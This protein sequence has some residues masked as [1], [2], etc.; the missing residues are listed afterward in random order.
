MPFRWP[1]FSAPPLI[2]VVIPTF[3]RTAELRLC[4]EG[5]SQQ[6]AP[7][8]QFELVIIDDGSTED[9]ASVAAAFEH[10]LKLEFVPSAHAGPGAA[11]NIGLKRARA[12][13]LILYDDD[14]RPRPNLVQ[15]CL[16]FH[17]L[18]P[19]EQD[20]S[21]LYFVPD[22]A[23]LGSAVVRWAF[24]RLYPFPRTPSVDG[25]LRFWSGT[26]TCKKSVFRHGQFDP[27]YQM[28]E[29]AELGLRLSRRID[30][31][32]H[33]EPVVSGTFTRPLTFQQ[34]CYRQYNI[35]YYSYIFARNYRGAV[36]YAFA[37]YDHPESYV[38]DG[39]KLTALLA[40][41]RGLEA[42]AATSPP[43]KLLGALWLRL[44]AHARA[45]GWIAAREGLPAE[46][47]GVLG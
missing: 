44:D 19:A 39:D 43:S 31:R 5:F 30:L 22:P 9:T 27:A 10:T 40:S 18:H 41:A 29:D 1:G 25:W 16:D 45:R 47:A 28:L 17:R 20:M 24:G 12:P 34:I 13:L 8:D 35:G 6:T 11:R 4:L 15:Y 2:S 23:I 33:F 42:A 38:V 32:V 26:L 3:N 21:L 36:D 14:L 46:P 7:R 37:P